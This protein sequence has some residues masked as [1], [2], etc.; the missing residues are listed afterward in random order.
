[1]TSQHHDTPRDATDRGGGPGVGGA[2]QGSP[3]IFPPPP[4]S[5]PAQPV[6][7]GIEAAASAGPAAST[8]YRGGDTGWGGYGHGGATTSPP[9][10]KNP[11]PPAPPGV[12]S[13]QRP[14]RL[15]PPHC[16][17]RTKG[18]C[19]RPPRENKQ[20]I[21][22]FFTGFYSKSSPRRDRRGSAP[23]GGGGGAVP[24]GCPRGGSQLGQGPQ[25]ALCEEAVGAAA[26]GGCPGEVGKHRGGGSG[27]RPGVLV[28][29]GGGDRGP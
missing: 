12:W 16:S 20:Q 14:P 5:P 27:V 3:V 24:G 2:P 17:G 25:A 13:P 22:G 8:D 10:P 6:I 4:P 19:Q 21:W 7:P 23:G 15:D 11:T 18:G 29:P 1:M 9:S 26:G 28:S